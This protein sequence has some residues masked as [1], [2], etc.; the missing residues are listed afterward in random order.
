M[1]PHFSSLGILNSLDENKKTSESA[2]EGT[3]AFFYDVVDCYVR[4]Q[5]GALDQ[6]ILTSILSLPRN[7]D[8][9]TLYRCYGCCKRQRRPTCGD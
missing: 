6:R 1:H 3:G 9:Y 7:N 5:A 2:G 8:L 4:S